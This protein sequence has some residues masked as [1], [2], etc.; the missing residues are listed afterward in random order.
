MSCG[1][2]DLIPAVMCVKN[3]FIELPEDA[4]RSALT[5]MRR[6][7]S[8]SFL[9]RA[10][11]RSTCHSESDDDLPRTC[12]VGG[13]PGAELDN[14]GRSSRPGQDSDEPVPPKDREQG[15]RASWRASE[16]GCKWAD[17]EPE[18]D[19]MVPVEEL[20]LSPSTC[21]SICPNDFVF[22]AS[23]E[24]DCELA[25]QMAFAY[26][27]P[28]GTFVGDEA[29]SSFQAFPSSQCPRPAPRLRG[30]HSEAAHRAFAA[31]R[32]A[33]DAH[34]Y[35]LDTGIERVEFLYTMPCEMPYWEKT[36]TDGSEAMQA[37]GDHQWYCPTCSLLKYDAYGDFCAYCGSKFS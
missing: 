27:S 20:S 8:D 37:M 28:A 31:A 7:L 17:I 25:N 12:T 13:E 2:A 3:T 5:Q 36:E 33:A 19:P 18:S 14:R 6:I 4:S 9:V 32:A 34:Q 11:S 10:G 1:Q 30:E 15:Q 24:E 23:S 21:D 16:S 29:A 22:D 26:W 35:N